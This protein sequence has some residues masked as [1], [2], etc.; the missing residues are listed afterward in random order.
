MQ[1]RRRV[2]V[3]LGRAK[4][5]DTSEKIEVQIIIYGL[6][7]FPYA[8]GLADDSVIHVV[9][10]DTGFQVVRCQDTRDAAEELIRVNMGADPRLLFLIRE[11]LDIRISA[12]G[13]DGDK[14]YA[15]MSSPVSVSVIPVV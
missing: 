8:I 6:I 12:A 7:K 1:N 10:D 9:F 3:L 14:R 11:R 13:Q 2:I 5:R 15:G 4:I